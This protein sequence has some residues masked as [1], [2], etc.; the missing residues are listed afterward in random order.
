[1]RAMLL[2][3]CLGAAGV[4][5]DS[6]GAR[7]SACTTTGSTLQAATGHNGAVMSTVAPFALQATSGGARFGLNYTAGVQVPITLVPTDGGMLKGFMCSVFK[8]TDTAGSQGRLGQVI[9]GAGQTGVRGICTNTACLT[10]SSATQKTSI[11]MLWS[12][13]ATAGTGSVNFQCTVVRDINTYWIMPAFVLKEA[14][15]VGGKPDNPTSLQLVGVVAGA[16]ATLSFTFAPPLAQGGILFYTLERAVQAAALVFKS[17]LN[18]TSTGTAVA[19]YSVSVSN[20]TASTA[21]VFRVRSYAGAV[22]GY[23]VTGGAPQ[24]N[25]TTPSGSVTLPP[26]PQVP[27]GPQS[28]PTLNLTAYIPPP[29]PTSATFLGFDVQYRLDPA[30][31]AAGSGTFVAAG[32]NFYTIPNAA[33]YVQY[34]VRIRA[35]STAGNSAWSSDLSLM[36]LS[37]CPNGCSAQGVCTSPDNVCDCNVGW[38]GEDCSVPSQVGAGSGGGPKG[39]VCFTGFCMDWGLASSTSSLVGPAIPAAQVTDVHFKISYPSKGWLGWLLDA[40]DGMTGGLGYY[41]TRDETAS[42]AATYAYPVV[43]PS[44][45]APGIGT[46]DNTVCGASSNGACSFSGSSGGAG[47]T[48]FIFRKSVR[49]SPALKVSASGSATLQDF[50]YA[51]GVTN[52]FEQ[53]VGDAQGKLIVD[54]YAGTVTKVGD[55]AYLKMY[56]SMIVFVGV[57]CLLGLLFSRWAWLRFSA[58]G[59][60]LF[61]RRLG[62]WSGKTGGLVGALTTDVVSTVQDMLVGEAVVFL[63]YGAALAVFIGVGYREFEAVGKDGVF[64]WGHVAAMHYAFV[65]LPVQKNS[66]W[67]WLFGSSFERLVK[68]HRILA[69]LALVFNYVHLL[70]M[71]GLYGSAVATSVQAQTMGLLSLIFFSLTAAAGFEPIR[72]SY[73][74]VFIAFHLIFAPLG[75]IF[76]FVH[77]KVSRSQQQQPSPSWHNKQQQR[78]CKKLE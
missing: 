65:L 71:I 57:A 41:H 10:H 24:V 36:V 55:A 53:H 12:P 76:A 29:L 18:V 37:L 68:W 48:T 77:V 6:S 30:P 44:L 35:K 16:S 40:K 39:P 72:R 73:Y 43:S 19:S 21:F 64:T 78:S 56:L 7:P 3:L 25:V 23:G 61:Q 63:L 59:N 62:T 50:A 26:T 28:S 14:I 2:L 32:T 51:W 31:Y 54:W 1:M 74:S 33:L 34:Y 70:T 58:L 15:P 4:R 27:S 46:F 42:P 67:C 8:A 52:G 5:A 22:N 49:T 45:S 60:G 47:S 66:V 11:S 75:Y 13:P 38:V 69:R 9:A 17:V 20:Q